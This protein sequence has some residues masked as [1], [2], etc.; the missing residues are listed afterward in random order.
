[1]SKSGFPGI[2]GF[3]GTRAPLMLDVLCLAM[4]GVV[5]VLAWSVYQVKFRRRYSAAQMDA[6]HAGAS[7]C[8][9]S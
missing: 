8:W 9:S 1:M 3:L 6:N 4:L 7:S 2:D 5:V